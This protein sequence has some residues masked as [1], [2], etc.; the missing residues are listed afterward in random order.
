MRIAFKTIVWVLV[1]VTVGLFYLDYRKTREAAFCAH[2]NMIQL[3]E[4]HGGKGHE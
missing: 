2:D 3:M 4:Q 1:L